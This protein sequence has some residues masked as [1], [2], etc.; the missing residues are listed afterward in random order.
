VTDG[1]ADGRTIVPQNSAHV[2]FFFYLIT[3]ES[4]NIIT[5]LLGET[6]RNGLV[7]GLFNEDASLT[8]R[9]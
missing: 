6:R 3:D 8:D 9:I 1:R 4:S 5:E 7:S 2:S